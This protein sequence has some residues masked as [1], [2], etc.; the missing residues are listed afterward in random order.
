[1]NKLRNVYYNS[2]RSTL[3]MSIIIRPRIFMHYVHKFED[4]KYFKH[5]ASIIDR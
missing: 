4:V 3:A 2:K 5:D 1:M